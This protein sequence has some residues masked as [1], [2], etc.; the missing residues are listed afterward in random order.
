MNA[1]SP[2]VA[3]QVLFLT[4]N[5]ETVCRAKISAFSVESGDKTTLGK[6]AFIY[7]TKLVDTVA[8]HEKTECILKN[9]G[10]SQAELVV[11]MAERR[12]TKTET[13]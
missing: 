11:S 10:I 12:L 2:V 13:T 5:P 6:Q 4:K 3:L 9:R 7:Q 8:Q 1:R